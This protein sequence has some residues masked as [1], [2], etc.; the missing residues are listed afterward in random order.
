MINAIKEKYKGFLRG[1]TKLGR[2]VREGLFEEVTFKL[3]PEGPSKRQVK[4]EER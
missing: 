3:K 4:M 1:L 2:V